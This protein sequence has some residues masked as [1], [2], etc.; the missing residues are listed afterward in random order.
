MGTAKQSA[1]FSADLP[2][3]HLQWAPRALWR[4]C[5]AVSAK[6]QAMRWLAVLVS[7]LAISCGSTSDGGSPGF[8]GS[9]GQAAGGGSGGGLSGGSGGGSGGNVIIDAALPDGAGGGGTCPDG[10]VP[11][12]PGCDCGKLEFKIDTKQSCSIGLE[13]GATVD[14]EGFISL[15]GQQHRVFAMDRW[16]KGHIVAWCDSTTLPELLAAFDVTGYLGQ[17]PTPRVA[18]FGD[19]FLCEPGKLPQQALPPSIQYQ[20]KDLP[21]KYKGNSAALA[22][23]FDVVIFCGFRQGWPN[24]WVTELGEFVSLHGKG[25]L[26]VMDYEGIVHAQDFS[27]MSAITQPSG[28]VFNP[29]NLAW[30]PSAT[31]VSIECVPDLPPPVK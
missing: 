22:Q 3:T 29:L 25:L 4:R 28:I 23:D 17:V 2:V 20:G 1:G 30:A 19:D 11:G 18:S 7:M 27:N 21:A 24:P 6:L 9:G 31:N 15:A 14:G 16:G 13:P 8:G 12:E 5:P 26:A 10:G